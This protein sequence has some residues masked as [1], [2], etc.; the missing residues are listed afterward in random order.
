MLEQHD[1]A[2]RRAKGGTRALALEALRLSDADGGAGAGVEEGD[3]EEEGG[4]KLCGAGTL[5]VPVLLPAE[6]TRL[7]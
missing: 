6:S 7:G 2:V 5:L 4:W 1:T 3:P